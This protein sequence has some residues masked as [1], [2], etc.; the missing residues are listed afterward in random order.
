MTA[1]TMSLPF[2]ESSI[3]TKKALI[4]V[5]VWRGELQCDQIGLIIALWATF[6]SQWQQLF[7]PNC[8]HC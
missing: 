6:L 4:D 2:S 5:K 8:T 1:I 3:L 7:C